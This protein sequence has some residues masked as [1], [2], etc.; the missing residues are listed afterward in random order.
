MRVGTKAGRGRARRLRNNAQ[1][2]YARWRIVGY[3]AAMQSHLTSD[4]TSLPR[5]AKLLA[6]AGHANIKFPTRGT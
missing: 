2:Y 1:R 6:G 4:L 3:A 5:I